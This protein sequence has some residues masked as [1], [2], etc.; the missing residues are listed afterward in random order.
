MQASD[1][2]A[3]QMRRDA[4]EQMGAGGQARVERYEVAVFE[5]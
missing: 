3:N 2:R 5:A 1:E 4:S